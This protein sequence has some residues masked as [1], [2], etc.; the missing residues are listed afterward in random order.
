MIARTAAIATAVVALCISVGCFKSSTTQ[1]SSGSS[2][3]FSSSP[4]KSS[5]KSSSDSDEAEDDFQRDVR[6]YTVR[7]AASEFDLQ[8]FQRGLSETAETYGITDWE[9]HDA[10]FVA[11]GRGLAKA[12]VSK[13]RFDELA[14]QMANKD[15]GNLESIESGYEMYRNQ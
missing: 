1:A 3:D 4:F 7:V 11:I 15:D 13:R 14:V 8:S 6:D 9:Q 2:S 10:T 12:D 5:S